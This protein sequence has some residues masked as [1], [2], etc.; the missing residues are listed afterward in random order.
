MQS[1][2]STQICQVIWAATGGKLR[3]PCTKIE[4]KLMVLEVRVQPLVNR[5]RMF[6]LLKIMNSS[7]IDQNQPWSCTNRQCCSIRQLQLCKGQIRIDIAQP[8]SSS[9]RSRLRRQLVQRE[10]RAKISVTKRVKL[11]IRKVIKPT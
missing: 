2:Q 5:L 4:S 3:L 10:A 9:S 8:K 6:I 11:L 1:K 7:P